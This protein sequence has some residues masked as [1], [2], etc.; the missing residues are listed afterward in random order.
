MK[1]WGDLLEGQLDL[2]EIHLVLNRWRAHNESQVCKQGFGDDR[3]LLGKFRLPIR[4]LLHYG[5]GPKPLRLAFLQ[6]LLG[7]SAAINQVK[8]T[9]QMVEVHL[10]MK[11]NN[12][13]QP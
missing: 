2:L 5:R 3:S 8:A 12:M 9:F 10:E 4:K 6:N 13:E 11:R 1:A 7:V